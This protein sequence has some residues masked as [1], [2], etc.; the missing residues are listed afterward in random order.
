MEFFIWLILFAFIFGAGYLFFWAFKTS[1][2]GMEENADNKVNYNAKDLS[3]L[4]HVSGLPLP[5][6]VL[7]DVMNCEDRIVFKKDNTVITI[8]FDKIWSIDSTTGDALKKQAAGA[9]AGKYVLG[10]TSGAI[11]GALLA[12][13]VYLVISYNSDGTDKYIILD[14]AYSGFFSNRLI[15]DFKKSP[16]KESRNIEL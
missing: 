5:P 4:I 3:K 16:P 9:V 13:K 14:E 12:T 2:K 1:I 7:V 10:G 8:K 15:K 6:D 11:F